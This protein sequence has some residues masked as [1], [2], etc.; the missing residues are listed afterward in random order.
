M[1]KQFLNE[2]NSAY[3]RLKLK[4]S[5]IVH[6]LFHRIFELESGWYSGHYHKGDNGSWF[7]LCFPI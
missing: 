2:I 1:D 7:F 6:A 3:Y 5:E 4:Q